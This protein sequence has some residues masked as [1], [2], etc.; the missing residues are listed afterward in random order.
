MKF[1]ISLFI[2]VDEKQ[3]GVENW[4]AK[5]CRDTSAITFKLSR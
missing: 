1:D 4:Q 2:H 3:L 5:A